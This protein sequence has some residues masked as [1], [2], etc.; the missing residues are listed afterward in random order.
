MDDTQYATLK[1]EL[2]TDP[3]GY[4]YMTA[5]G[6]SDYTGA[7]DLFNLAR[8]AIQIP[9]AALKSWDI[10]TAVVPSEWT[11]GMS[12]AGMGLYFAALMAIG[13]SQQG[14]I[15]LTNGNIKAALDLM[16][17][18]GTCPLTHAAMHALYTRNG[19]RAEQLFGAG[20]II[21]I[22]DLVYVRDNLGF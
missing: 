16:F 17:P 6:N 13:N 8:A 12:A 2:V 20:T 5:I 1:T 7:T 19:S 9:Q 10:F 21:T 11:A 4:G 22:D 18:T 14:R 3:N 15:D